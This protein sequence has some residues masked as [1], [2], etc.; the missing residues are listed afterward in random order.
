MVLWFGL[1]LVMGVVF[2]EAKRPFFIKDNKIYDSEGG[3]RIFHGV[4]VVE[5]VPPY[6]DI[7]FNETDMKKLK[8]WGIN[9]M[10]LGM[11][12]PGVEPE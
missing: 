4:N 8:S 10:R 6:Y 7:H 5:K 2:A 3:T 11:M 9:G 1:L 12:W